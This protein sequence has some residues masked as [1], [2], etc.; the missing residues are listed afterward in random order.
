MGQ[1]SAEIRREIEE[2]RERMGDTAEQLGYQADIPAR[3]RER[4][5]DRIESVKGTIG[6]AVSAVTGGSGDRIDEAR[7]AAGNAVGA[8]TENPLGLVLGALAVGFLAGLMLP[9]SDAER[10]SVRPISRTIADRA[11]TTM[12]EA[13][14]A[15]KAVVRETAAAAMSSVQQHGAEVAQHAAGTASGNSA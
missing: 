1:D 3:L 11:Q 14:E 15:G 13:V 6:D 2:T 10:S 5:N 7:E 12:S 8:V 4:V 9:M